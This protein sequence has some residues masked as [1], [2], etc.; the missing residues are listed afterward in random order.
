[1]KG[2]GWEMDEGMRRCA[3]REAI[4][5]VFTAVFMCIHHTLHPTPHT[6]TRK[7]WLTDLKTAVRD[8]EWDGVVEEKGRVVLN[9]SMNWNF[10]PIHTTPNSCLESATPKGEGGKSDRFLRWGGIVGGFRRL[11]DPRSLR[12]EGEK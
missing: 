3:C 2:W 7:L 11:V 5:R 9:S 8:E 4:D 6:Q 1:M 12:G 10:V